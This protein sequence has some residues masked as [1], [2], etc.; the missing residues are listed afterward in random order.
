MGGEWIYRI[1][2]GKSCSFDHIQYSTVLYRHWIQYCTVNQDI[3]ND[4]FTVSLVLFPSVKCCNGIVQLR[5]PILCVSIFVRLCLY[6]V[7]C[8]VFIPWPQPPAP[9]ARIIVRHLLVL[10]TSIASQHIFCKSI[11][12]RTAP[13]TSN[14]LTTIPIPEILKTKNTS[15]IESINEISQHY[16]WRC[17]LLCIENV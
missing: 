15:S 4:S 8:V 16:L 17:H 5:H 1:N 7:W 12:C 11:A 6:S 14:E 3:G 9:T 2:W 10:P 13:T